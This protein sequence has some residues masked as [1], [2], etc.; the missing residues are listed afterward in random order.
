MPSRTGSEA[1]QVCDKYAYYCSLRAFCHIYKKKIKKST[2]TCN[3]P[4]FSNDGVSFLFFFLPVGFASG[5]V[6]PLLLLLI[7]CLSVL[8]FFLFG[9]CMWA[10]TGNT[11]VRRR[12]LIMSVCA[13]VYG[14][15]VTSLPLEETPQIKHG[16]GS[17]SDSRGGGGEKKERV[18][19]E[20]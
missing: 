6:H 9:T 10:G 12:L 7:S 18:R 5:C 17:N 2:L 4:F 16:P 13:S 1:R 15:F 3:S 20:T 19:F 8:S 14:V 11:P